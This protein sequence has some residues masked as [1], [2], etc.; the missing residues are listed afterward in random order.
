MCKMVIEF[1]SCI[2]KIMHRPF[3]NSKMVTR[4]IVAIAIKFIQ[5][6]LRIDMPF[7]EIGPR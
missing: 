3:K 6:I 7:R 1:S 4:N 5:D 2:M